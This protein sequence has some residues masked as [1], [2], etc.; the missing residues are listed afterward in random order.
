MGVLLGI[1]GFASTNL[2]RRHR[3]RGELRG[4]VDHARALAHRFQAS[5]VFRIRQ[6]TEISSR[7]ANSTPE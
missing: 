5:G 4:M 1:I 6:F 3:W 2:F 7:F